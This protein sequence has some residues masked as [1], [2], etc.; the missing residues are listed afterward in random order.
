MYNASLPT[1]GPA[2]ESEQYSDDGHEE[3]TIA[4]AGKGQ[5]PRHLKR[6]SSHH[7]EYLLEW[8]EPEEDSEGSISKKGS[9]SRSIN[10][11]EL[12]G[13]DREEG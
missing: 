6:M 9:H 1:T 10:Q 4:N 3:C 12:T 11:G 8:S 2:S 5:S 7:H 13:G